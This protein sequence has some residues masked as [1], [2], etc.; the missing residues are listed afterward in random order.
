MNPI[1]SIGHSTHSA[2]KLRQLLA[3]HQISAV[4]DVRSSPYSRLNPQFNRETL[5]KNLRS[6]HI[7]Y[8]FLGTELGARTED[9]SCYVEGRVQY[10]LLARTSLFQQ[11]LD[12]ACRGAETHRIALLC[13]EKEP[14]EC[15]RCILVSRHLVARGADVRHILQDGVLESHGD[16]VARLLRELRLEERELFRS[17]EDLVLEAYRRLTNPR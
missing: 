15:H 3:A 14:L 8:V 17:H 10:D 9:R 12:R 16:T 4:A 5:C 7:S 1:F 13:A 2:D 6:G 11:G